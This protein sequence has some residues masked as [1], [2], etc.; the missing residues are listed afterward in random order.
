MYSFGRRRS[1]AAFAKK[2][3]KKKK[4]EGLAAY[5]R[6]DGTRKVDLIAGNRCRPIEFDQTMKGLKTIALSSAE[7]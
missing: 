4:V 3:K 6:R 2:K 1:V 7:R 5:L